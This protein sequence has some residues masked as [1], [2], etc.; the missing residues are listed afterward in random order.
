MKK[1]YFILSFLLFAGFAMAQNNEAIASSCKITA[2]ESIKIVFDESLNCTNAPGDL[3]GMTNIGFHSGFNT[4][5]NVVDWNAAT[6]QQMTNDGNDIF[7]L[8]ITPATYYA[9]CTWA[10]LV[11]V[12]FVMNQGPSVPDTPWGSEGKDNN[13]DGTACQDFFLTIANMAE[14]ESS[15]VDVALVNSLTV[16]PNPFSESTVISFTNS[17]NQVYDI[18]VSS[19]TGQVVR[20]FQNVSGN[21]VELERGNMTAGM[22]F[23][24]FQSETGKIATTKVVVR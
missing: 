20:Q 2:S 19:L 12:N 9:N 22:Y 23:V 7:S 6:A 4:W 21:S 3:A 8:T 24:T 11:V 5:T 17:N 16:T 13:A 14:C 18:T 15:T 1:F 10:D